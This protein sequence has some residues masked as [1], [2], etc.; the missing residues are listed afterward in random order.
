MVDGE[1]YTVNP[2]TADY[3]YD[4]FEEFIVLFGPAISK[5]LGAVDKGD[6]GKSILEQDLNLEALSQA[7]VELLVGFKGERGNLQRF[8]K[9]VLINTYVG[10]SSQSVCADFET[11]FMGAY[12]HGLKLTAFSFAEQYRDFFDGFGGL[13]NVLAV[14]AR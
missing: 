12:L 3:G 13:K 6:S 10:E 4:L 2:F 7:V 14:K 1:K 11:R 5:L 8:M 9:K